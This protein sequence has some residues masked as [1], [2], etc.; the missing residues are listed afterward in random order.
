MVEYQKFCLEHYG[1]VVTAANKSKEI[2]PTNTITEVAFL[3][4]R[5]VRKTI[6]DGS[7]QWVAPLEL[8]SIA[9]CM[10]FILPSNSVDKDTQLIESCISA[11]RELVLHFDRERHH[12]FRTDICNLL[13]SKLNRDVSVLYKVFPTYEKIFAS[14]FPSGGDNG[15]TQN[16]YELQALN[17]TQLGDVTSAAVVVAECKPSDE[18]RRVVRESTNLP[19]LALVVRE[20]LAIYKVRS[21]VLM[22]DINPLMNNFKNITRQ[23]TNKQLIDNTPLPSNNNNRWKLNNNMHEAARIITHPATEAMDLEDLVCNPQMRYDPAISQAY[24]CRLALLRNIEAKRRTEEILVRNHRRLA[25][26]RLTRSKNLKVVT[27]STVGEMEDGPA[28][29]ERLGTNLQVSGAPPEQM[30]LLLQPSETSNG[31]NTQFALDDFFERPFSIYDSQFAVGTAP[32][33]E[34]EVWELWSNSEAVRMKMRNYTY[35]KGTLHVRISVTG[36]PFHYGRF[37][38]SYYPYAGYNQILDAL[39]T[40]IVAASRM[41]FIYHSQ[42]SLKQMTI[43]INANQPLDVEIPFCSPKQAFSLM[44]Y[45]GDAIIPAVAFV[46]FAVAGTLYI[47]AINPI[48]L[49][50]DSTDSPISINVMAWATNVELSV[51]TST[52][53][54]TEG[55]AKKSVG[56][57]KSKKTFSSETVSGKAAKGFW[58]AI[59]HDPKN[60]E[61]TD[62]GPLT[63]VSSVVADLGEKLSDVPFIG[64]FAQATGKIAGKLGQVFSMFG[65][66][67]PVVLE[68]PIFVKNMAYTNGATTAGSETTYKLSVDP[69]QE[70][71]VDPTIAGGIAED[72]LCFATLNS[73]ESYLTS[74]SWT[75]A[76]T[77]LVDE[78]FASQV[79]P[80]LCDSM[81]NTAEDERFIQ[82]TILGFTSIPFDY[83]HGDITFRFDI[84]CSKF[85]RGKLLITF[86]PNIYQRGL[87]LSSPATFNQQNSLIIDIQ[88]V[89][90]V[91]FEIQ[92]CSDWRWLPLPTQVWGGFKSPTF[93]MGDET[94]FSET[95][96]GYISVTPLNELVQP[97]DNAPISVNVYVRSDRMEYAVPTSISMPTG[98]VYTESKNILVPTGDTS[99]LDTIVNFGEKLASFRPLLKRYQVNTVVETDVTAG[100]VL[101]YNAPMYPAIQHGATFDTG[102]SNPNIYEYLRYAYFAMRGGFRYRFRVLGTTT[103]ATWV[104]VNRDYADSSTPFGTY[105]VFPF[106]VLT[107]MGT[108]FEGGNAYHLM[109]NGGVEFEIPYY[110]NQNFMISPQQN[111]M[112]TSPAVSAPEYLGMSIQAN[113]SGE[114][115][116]V[117]ETST[118]EDFNFSR[119]LGAPYFVETI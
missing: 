27:E 77:A 93:A 10:G 49:A 112:T 51:P 40:P 65:W 12:K 59:E 68:K 111:Y 53:V 67:R 44:N 80:T 25:A 61:Y 11:S 24:K 106:D 17:L 84:V 85:H 47:R 89:Q 46:D 14:M 73:R 42:S 110:C 66:S 102:S 95:S 35:F 81:I 87:I 105:S 2:P 88:E 32:S 98:R 20:H 62:P 38:V 57:Q 78:L 26:R 37:M 6:P 8:A 74:F 69:K 75:S 94:T 96:L 21:L 103:N 13:G 71:T 55:K 45:T 58:K 79:M 56:G 43:D 3:K 36:T 108:G 48:L 70:T 101:F 82:P 104:T 4:R 109:T 63:Q 23:F 116:A 86:E 29:G 64:S 16:E 15:E 34:L 5:F 1:M 41:P 90:D 92:W 118:A 22:V 83:W 117:L 7:V 91:E 33:V 99:E 97:V 72:E 28:I 30:S 114:C 18:Y 76:D 100:N 115:I 9:K 107:I 113:V 60:S 31:N 19:D 52:V 39:S 50:M 54:L 119:F